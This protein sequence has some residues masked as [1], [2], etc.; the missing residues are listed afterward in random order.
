MLPDLDLE[1]IADPSM[2]AVIVRLLNVVETLTAEVRPLREENQRRR[3]ENN[4]R[5]GEQGKPTVL[6]QVQ[7]KA[8]TPATNHSS[9]QE[10]REP[11]EHHKG[12]K[13]CRLTISREQVVLVDRAVLPKDAAR[14]GFAAV[15][16]QDVVFRTDTIRFRKEQ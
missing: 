5:T 11:R 12:G 14:K 10:R 8:P 16:V 2:R 15:V 4:R 9:E 3:D 13:R 7:P 6:P 1:R